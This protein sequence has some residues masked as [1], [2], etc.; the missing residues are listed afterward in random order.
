MIH[1]ETFGNDSHP[2][3]E[4]RGR[5]KKKRWSRLVSILTGGPGL[6]FSR[7]LPILIDNPQIDPIVIIKQ[8]QIL[9]TI[10][11]LLLC[12]IAQKPGVARK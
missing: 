9:D 12:C 5:G 2:F 8:K 3:R 4:A 11:L 1:G 10:T 7:N 6:T